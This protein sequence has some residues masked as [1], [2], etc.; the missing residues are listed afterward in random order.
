MTLRV[1]VRGGGDLASGVVYR[2]YR[3]GWHVIVTELSQPRAVRRTVSFAQAVYDGQI[4]IEGVVGKRVASTG[5]IDAVLGEGDVPVIVDP[6]LSAMV[7][8]CPHVIVDC[9]MLKQSPGGQL[10]DSVLII[11]IGPGFTAGLDCHAVVETNRGP[12]L[13]R[14]IWSGRAQDDTGLPEA[15]GEHR[16]A[17]VL[18][19]P[20]GG[21][22]QTLLP[23]GSMLKKGDVVAR[24]AGV[25]VEA[26]FDS[27]LRGLIQDG[28]VVDPG[29]KIGDADPRGDARLCWLISEKALAVGGGVLE[30]ILSWQPL[31]MVLYGK[32]T[33]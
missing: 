13:G 21:S 19:A 8:F 9:R 1:L 2:L 14:V 15:V 7:H 25:P 26:P 4:S 16:G 12:F 17:R 30:T 32:G 22:V 3:A 20:V 31:R 29:E 23:I 18:R 10:I 27:V 24:V 28:I 33:A 5:D 11:G 6:E